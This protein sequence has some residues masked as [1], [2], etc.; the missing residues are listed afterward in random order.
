M[1][2]YAVLGGHGCELPLHT[3]PDA[4]GGRARHQEGRDQG[5][6]TR[7]HADASEYGALATSRSRR[8]VSLL[9]L[10]NGAAGARR[11]VGSKARRKTRLTTSPGR[12]GRRRREAGRRSTGPFETG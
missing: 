11:H 4:S 1:V 7:A 3:K 10:L 9:H 12:I 8:S 6:R 5:E 2:L